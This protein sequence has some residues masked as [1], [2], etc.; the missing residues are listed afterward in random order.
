MKYF[1]CWN[2]H[3]DCENMKCDDICARREGKKDKFS[4]LTEEGNKFLSPV[5][6]T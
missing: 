4:Y 6:F 2:V 1:S 5:S 3:P